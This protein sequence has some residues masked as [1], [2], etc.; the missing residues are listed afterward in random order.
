MMTQLPFS[1]PPCSRSWASSAIGSK[2]LYRHLL[3]LRCEEYRIERKSANKRGL[4]QLARISRQLRINS[5]WRHGRSKDRQ[6]LPASLPNVSAILRPG[7]VVSFYYGNQ[8]R[9]GSYGDDVKRQIADKIN[10]FGDCLV[11]VRSRAGSLA[12]NP[13]FLTHTH[14]IAELD[15]ELEIGTEVFFGPYPEKEDDKKRAITI[16]M[17]DS[18]G[19]TRG[20]PH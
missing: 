11:A 19:V 12:L 6:A 17:P 3:S 1:S 5:D 13:E 4:E 14:E 2:D 18:D 10:V 15:S 16:T 20:H 8:I 7:S 9:I